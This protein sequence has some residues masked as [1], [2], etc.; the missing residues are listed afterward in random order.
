MDEQ[1]F[2]PFCL[3]NNDCSRHR[4]G[5]TQR[6]SRPGDKEAPAGETWSRD[7]SLTFASDTELCCIIV[8]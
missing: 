6:Q 4:Q 7:D 5:A 3:R 2:L 8:I 1:F